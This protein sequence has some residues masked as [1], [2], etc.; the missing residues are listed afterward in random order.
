MAFTNHQNGQYEQSIST[1]FFTFV[2][3][4]LIIRNVYIINTHIS[5]YLPVKGNDIPV[6]KPGSNCSL[7]N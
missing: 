4:N 5:A 3:W 7:L 6:T 1:L 2:V